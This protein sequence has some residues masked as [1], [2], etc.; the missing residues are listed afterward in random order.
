MFLAAKS[1]CTKD[2]LDKY[3]IPAA[4]CRQKLSRVCLSMVTGTLRRDKSSFTI[5]TSIF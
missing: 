2:L 3:T 5:L 4:I 1:L